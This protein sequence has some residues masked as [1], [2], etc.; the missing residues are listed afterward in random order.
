MIKALA[1]TS[2]GQDKD[3]LLLTYK[4]LIRSRIDYAAPIW[5][6]NAKPS[7]LLRLQRVQN[8]ALR[9]ATGCHRKSSWQHLHNEARILSIEEHARLLAAQFLAAASQRDHPSHEV[10]S[11]RPGPRNMKATLQSALG[12]AVSPHLVDGIIPAC[13]LGAART[14]LYSAAVVNSAGYRP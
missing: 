1:G 8:S 11:R 7:S 4:A 5:L 6:P 9:I 12:D 2:W 13:G 14:A 10:I 3:T